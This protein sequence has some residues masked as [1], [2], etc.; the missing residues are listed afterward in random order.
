MNNDEKKAQ[1][2]RTLA[3][4]RII[5][6]ILAEE[7]KERDDPEYHLLR[8]HERALENGVRIDLTDDDYKKFAETR[9]E[10]PINSIVEI[11]PHESKSIADVTPKTGTRGV[12]QGFKIVVPEAWAVFGQR[13]KEPAIIIGVSF[14]LPFEEARGEV[15]LKDEDG[16]T[17]LFYFEQEN[18]KIIEKAKPH[19]SLCYKNGEFLADANMPLFKKCQTEKGIEFEGVLAFA[20]TPMVEYF[21]RYPIKVKRT[22]SFHLMT[23]DLEDRKDIRFEIVRSERFGRYEDRQYLYLERSFLES[24]APEDVEILRQ[25]EDYQ[26]KEIK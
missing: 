20:E 11:L 17:I 8:E 19:T 4:D 15:W 3:V 9:Q 18:V 24:I 12:I 23:Y 25:F 16:G 26:V 10:Y 6:E 1:K 2:R 22:D 21:S 14:E 7:K 13:F 5:K